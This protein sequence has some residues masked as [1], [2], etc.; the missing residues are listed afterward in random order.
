MALR[1]TILDALLD[2]LATTGLD[3]VSVRTVAAQAQ[4]SPAAVQYHFHTK[5]QLL[6]AAFGRLR[7][8]MDDR[9]AAVDPVGPPH[10]VL[11]RYLLCWLP[12]DGERRGD[13]SAWLAFTTAAVT[14]PDLS[15][16]VRENDAVV[17]DGLAG[18]VPAE[19]AAVLLAVVDGLAL[20]MLAS[21]EPTAL[22]PTLDTAL[23]A[24]LSDVRRSR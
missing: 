14:R 8:R 24:L 17:L 12:L 4:V 16:V 19:I 10:E 21:P 2:V 11:R 15:A 22:L 5:E 7:A 20:R 3:G 23:A 13:V 6:A 18:L 1:E 9:L